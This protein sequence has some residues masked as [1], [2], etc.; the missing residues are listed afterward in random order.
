M[1][2]ALARTRV[3]HSLLMHFL[4]VRSLLAVVAERDVR[5]NATRVPKTDR[6]PGAD[7]RR[8]SC[9]R[10]TGRRSRGEH[11][12]LAHGS[13]RASLA[14]PVAVDSPAVTTFRLRLQSFLDLTAQRMT[15]ERCAQDLLGAHSDCQCLQTIADIG[16]VFALTI[17]AEAGDLR[18][19]HHH[20]QFLKL[21]GL[22]LATR[23]SGTA[24]G[25]EHLSKQGNARLRCALWFAGR[26]AVRLRE[27][28]IRDK[29]ERYVRNAP[30]SLD[31]QRKAYTAIGAKM[32]RISYAVIRMDHT[33]R[34]YYEHDL[35]GGSISLKRA[36]EA[37]HPVLT[38]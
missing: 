7:T 9:R 35:P 32:A 31:P 14:L 11:A 33:Q 38:S 6:D 36:V 10:R 1:T 8:L 26:I 25:R 13:R 20:R 22:Y 2:L 28:S 21:S 23:Q 5:A 16:P 29:Y 19:F 15:L 4:P 18:R 17:L 3:Q 30:H 34:S 27:R 24:S 12:R 37:H